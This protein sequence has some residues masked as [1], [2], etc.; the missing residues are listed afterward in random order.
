MR[1]AHAN[2]SG[3]PKKDKVILKTLKP[4]DIYRLANEMKLHGG[5]TEGKKYKPT[6]LLAE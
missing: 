5:F 2:K 3:I 6:S 4:P 1:K